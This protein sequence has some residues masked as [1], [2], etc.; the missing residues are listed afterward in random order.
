MS[1]VLAWVLAGL[2]ALLLINVGL[3]LLR[4]FQ[5]RHPHEP[6]P[7]VDVRLVTRTGLEIPV[8]CV[9]AGRFDGIHR[10]EV[11][12]PVGVAD[13]SEVATVRIGVLPS[14]TAI[15]MFLPGGLEP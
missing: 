8:Q 9:Y 12:R 6:K 1:G 3:G 15:A 14:K 2:V 4:A 11:I 5:H 7:P 13:P 10:W